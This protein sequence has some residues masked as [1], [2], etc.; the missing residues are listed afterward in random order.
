MIGAFPE[1]DLL[2]GGHDLAELRYAAKPFA[3]LPVDEVLLDEIPRV[4]G[5]REIARIA[6]KLP[7]VDP[8][9]DR[10]RLRPPFAAVVDDA[11]RIAQIVDGAI[12]ICTLGQRDVGDPERHGLYPGAEPGIPE[13]FRS[14][15]QQPRGLDV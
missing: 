9:D 1:A 8:A 11:G 3:M 6:G 7:G 13:R 2:E 15:R 10:L 14:P 4:R 12:V 5:G